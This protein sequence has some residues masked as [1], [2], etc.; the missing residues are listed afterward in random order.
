MPE[1]DGFQL[2]QKL[3]FK[4]FDLIITTA[5][6]QYAIQAFRANAIDYLLKPIDPDELI[7]AV[8]KVQKRKGSGNENRNLE[9]ILNQIITKQSKY[10]KI[11]LSLS[12]KVVLIEPDKIIYCKSEGSYTR[13]FMKGDEKLLVS[14]SIKTLENLCPTGKFMRVHKSYIVNVDEIQEY[15]RQGGGELVLSNGMVVPVSRTH[16]NEVLIALN[17]L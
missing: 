9:M 14:K 13:V 7:E 11:P 17:I 4:N 3:Q 12:N 6:N 5:Y 8:H 1:I 16:K 2:L 10:P 15:V